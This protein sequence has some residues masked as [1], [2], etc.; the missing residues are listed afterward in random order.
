MGEAGHPGVWKDSERPT[1]DFLRIFCFT[2][3]SIHVHFHMEGW[4]YGYKMC[5]WH[6]GKEKH[7]PCFAIF[8]WGISSTNQIHG[9][10]KTWPWVVSGMHTLGCP[11]SHSLSSNYREPKS[12]KVLAVTI[13]GNWD[14]PMDMKVLGIFTTSFFQVTFWSPK[15]R[16]LSPWKGHLKHRKGHNRKNLV[17]T[18][19]FGGGFCL[20]K[21]HPWLPWKIFV[22]II[23]GSI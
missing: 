20:H 8:F 17:E 1:T 23:F 9:D 19:F 13:A 2:G 22:G 5:C 7:F 14:N 15:W 3:K 6:V 4:W 12:V 16:S 18:C 11:P 10:K 21:N